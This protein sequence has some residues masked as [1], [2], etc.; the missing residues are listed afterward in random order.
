MTR[1]ICKTITCLAV[2]I[3]L[4]GCAMKLGKQPRHEVQSLY[5]AR[6]PEFQQAAGSLLGPEFVG[7]NSISTLVN[8]DEIF[9][10][11]LSAIRSAKRSINLETYVFWDGEIAQKFTAALSERAR[12]GVA[13]NL[14]LDAQGTQKMGTENAAQL[15]NAGAQIVKY[16]SV[17]WPDPR[18]YNNRSH[19]KLLIVDGTVAF[20]GGAGIA[21]LWAGNADSSKH[22]R[23]NHYK[24]TGPVVAQ[25]Q[26]SF[27]SNWLK[28]RGDV[29]HGDKYFPPLEDSGSLQ[30]QAIR[31]GAHYENLDLMYL[32][33][34]ASAKKSLR[35]ENA[36]FLP[37]D[38]VRKELV[39]AAKRG[40]RVEII[41]PGKKIDQKLVRSASRRHWPELLN[42]GIKI[43]EYQPTMVHV[44]LMIVDDKF[45]S[46]GSGNFDNRSIRLNDEANLD[47]LS[48]DFA[49]QQTNLFE[50]DKKRSHEVSPNEVDGFHLG[51]PF[52][53]L[54]GLFSP[55]L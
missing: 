38:L 35:I 1:I 33:A 46:V 42:A 13:V 6:S 18:R 48:A 20:I 51:D 37:D 30:A 27:V 40:A 17:L 16:H 36:Y 15:R 39:A 2:A 50:L 29:L 4:D 31:S 53:H 19:R 22:W 41:V 10:A 54:A 34:I 9:P 55:Q 25:L 8:G 24:V 5:S 49:A 23:D 11:M 44:K 47:V 28:T 52:E 7:G 32:L 43:Y 14:I 45:V 3:V 26:G 12:A 21:D